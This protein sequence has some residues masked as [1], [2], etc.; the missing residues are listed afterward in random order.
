MGPIPPQVACKLY[1]SPAPPP[2]PCSLGETN[3]PA[4]FQQVPNATT[5]GESPQSPCGAAGRAGGTA[6]GALREPGLGSRVAA[7]PSLGGSRTQ[8]ATPSSVNW[9]LWGGW[10]CQQRLGY[11]GVALEK[12]SFHLKDGCSFS[13]AAWAS[14]SSNTQAWSG[15]G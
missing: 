1:S 10:G 8:A 9:D 3:A 2:P 5:F 15:Q 12:L 6:G 7:G 11:A 14:S 4:A 13:P